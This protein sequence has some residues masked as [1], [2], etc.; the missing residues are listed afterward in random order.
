MVYN[1]GS[2]G[3]GNCT[4]VPESTSHFATL[5]SR[6]RPSALSAYCLHGY[7]LCGKLVA[8]WHR[9]TADVTEKIMEV[10][11]ARNTNAIDRKSTVPLP[12]AQP[13]NTPSDNFLRCP[14]NPYGVPGTPETA[15]RPKF[16]RIQPG[17][18]IWGRP[19][20]QHILGPAVAKVTSVKDVT[21]ILSAIEQGD[22]GAAE[23]L[24]SLRMGDR[25]RD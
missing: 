22:L 3:G 8:A 9:L 17:R 6:R 1:R 15:E 24:L 19:G 18:L 16:L 7:R 21:R 2:G 11:S 5:R 23:K 14:W 25:N 20:R 4:R 13:P 12:P 10:A